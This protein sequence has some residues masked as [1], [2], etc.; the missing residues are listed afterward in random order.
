MASTNRISLRSRISVALCAALITLPTMAA[1]VSA[2]A[3]DAPKNSPNAPLFA[4]ISQ[5]HHTCAVDTAGEL[6]CWGVYMTGVTT[7]PTRVQGLATPVKAVSVGP[8]VSMFIGSVTCVIDANSAAKCWGSNDTGQVG[9]GTTI[10]RATPTQVS[11]LTSGVRAISTGNGTACAL[12]D[13]NEVAC[14]GS[15]IGNTPVRVSVPSDTISIA[16][17]G[18]SRCI[19]RESGTV[20]CW[21][22]NGVG[23]LGLGNTINQTIPTPVPGLSNVDSIT[24][25]STSYF[26]AHKSDNSV[27]CWGYN[28]QGQLG[29]GNTIDQTSPT[30]VPPPAMTG[31]YVSV[32]A[33]MEFTCALT[34]GGQVACWGDNDYKQ[35]GDGTTTDST[36]AKTIPGISGALALAVG[37]ASA[38]AVLADRTLKCWGINGDGRLSIGTSVDESTPRAVVGFGTLGTTTTTSTTSTTV[39]PASPTGANPSAAW[40]TQRLKGAYGGTVIQSSTASATKTVTVTK[41]S[42]TLFLRTGPSAGKVK[43]SSPKASSR[44]VD[45]YSKT[46][47]TKAVT[48][49][50]KSASLQS[51][52]LTVLASKNPRSKGTTVS[53]DAYTTAGKTCGKGCVRSPK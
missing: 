9:D 39:A 8:T 1:R 12:L 32:H 5:H 14:W 34:T 38:C 21:G 16:N 30:P 20:S 46:S 6:W 19:L 29:N 50:T 13:L 25:G 28:G 44:T 26:C 35:L 51:V 52:T 36:S 27:A 48:L 7:T 42:V 10:N 41:K 40:A 4:Q 37:T 17:S 2:D 24:A 45:L 33:G 15:G 43:I 49:T 53:F 3:N 23:Q 31:P 18:N 11:G 47:G 22:N